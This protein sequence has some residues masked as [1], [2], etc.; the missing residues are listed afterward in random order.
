MTT[1][2]T[3]TPALDQLRREYASIVAEALPLVGRLVELNERFRAANRGIYLDAVEEQA[4]AT[5]SRVDDIAGG[6]TVMDLAGFDD[7]WR[8]LALLSAVVLPWELE[9]GDLGVLRRW[10]ADNGAPVSTDFEKRVS[11]G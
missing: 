3:P 6:T 11:F 10:A 7:A 9:H 1:A 4:S 8:A 2:A 5:G